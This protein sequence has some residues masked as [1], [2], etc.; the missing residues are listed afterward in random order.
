MIAYAVQS[1]N[2]CHL[3]GY[4]PEILDNP[5]F[6]HETAAREVLSELNKKAPLRDDIRYLVQHFNNNLEEIEKLLIKLLAT[7]DQW[8]SIIFQAK[9]QRQQLEKILTHV[10]EEHLNNTSSPLSPVAS[11]L[12]ILADHAA[13]NFNNNFGG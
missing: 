1:L 4:T 9:D 3:E 7:R 12:A 11:E 5:E 6:A 2:R 10:I 8:L 13:S